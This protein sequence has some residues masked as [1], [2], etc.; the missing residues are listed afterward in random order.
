[1]PVDIAQELKGRKLG[2]VL[3]KLGKVTREQ[4]HEAL[5]V[6]KTKKAPIGQLLV[7]L[8]YCNPRDIHAALAGQAGMEYVD[9]SAMTIEPD[10]LKVLPA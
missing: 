4:V 3:T 6:Q 1:M 5:A 10:V 9:L 2:R 8:G 7:E